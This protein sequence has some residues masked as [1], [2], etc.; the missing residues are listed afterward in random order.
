MPGALTLSIAKRSLVVA[1]VFVVD[2]LILGTVFAQS[3]PRA[4]KVFAIFL[5]PGFWLSLVLGQ[6]I[7]DSGFVLAL[8]VDWALYSATAFSVLRFINHR[9]RGF[10]E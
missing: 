7:G 6:T 9:R 3:A 1:F 4:G 8:L 5:F 10:S 2:I